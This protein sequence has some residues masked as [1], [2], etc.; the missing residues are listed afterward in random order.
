MYFFFR[1]WKDIYKKKNCARHW[2]LKQHEKVNFRV[3]FNLLFSF[4]LLEHTSGD[5]NDPRLKGRNCGFC[6]K[7]ERERERGGG[8][9][10]RKGERGS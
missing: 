4:F 1:I 5:D 6:L 9:G 10:K 3:I 2:I 8:G 7:N